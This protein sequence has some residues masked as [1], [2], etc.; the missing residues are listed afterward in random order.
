MAFGSFSAVLDIIRQNEPNLLNLAGGT[1]F[2]LHFPIPLSF[3][4]HR[5]SFPLF[6]AASSIPN[7]FPTFFSL[8]SLFWP[9]GELQELVS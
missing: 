2:A 4:C 3:F 9:P 1:L 6:F 7:S 5:P 8:I